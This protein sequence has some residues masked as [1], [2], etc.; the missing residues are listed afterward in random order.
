MAP[1]NAYRTALLKLSGNAFADRNGRG[2]SEGH[3]EFICRQI[4]EGYGV[5]SQLAVVVGG[6]NILRGAVFRPE[7]HERLRADYAG[8]IAT[9]VNAL[10]L[11]DGLER[12][13]VRAAVYGPWPVAGVVRP[14][15]EEPCRAELQSGRVVILSGGTGN[16]LFTTDTGAALRAV[17]L[18]AEIMLKATRVEGVYSGD[19]EKDSKA[20]LYERLNYDEVLAR[21]LG[22]MDMCA[23]S[24]C[25]DHALPVRVFNY[26]TEG[27][28]RRVLAGEQIGTLLGT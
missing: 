25:R 3:V 18:G 6:G 28:I 9:M 14:F 24:L 23:V 4:A 1:G 5:C 15:A 10:V 17:Q 27:N 20:Q 13:G 8:M 11:Q 12:A 19:P 22:V 16:P 2:I 26:R 21:R 7:G